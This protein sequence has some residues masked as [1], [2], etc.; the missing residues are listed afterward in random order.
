VILT[1][2]SKKQV[3]TK[4]DIEGDLSKS[5]V[6][7]LDAIITL[8][9]NAFI[10][11]LMPSI[12]NSINIYSVEKSEKENKKGFFEKLFSKDDKQKK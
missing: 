4:I 1:N 5:K 7:T 9:R 12:E 2:P 3:A 11:A 8:L 10:R 6:H